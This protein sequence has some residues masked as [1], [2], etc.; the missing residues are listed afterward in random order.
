MDNVVQHKLW[1]ESHRFSVRNVCGKLCG[2]EIL[3]RRGKNY[4]S[5]SNTCRS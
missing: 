2:P 1:F 4:W 5:L 3:N